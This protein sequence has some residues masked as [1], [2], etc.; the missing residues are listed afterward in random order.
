MW[1]WLLGGVIL[2]ACTLTFIVLAH[3]APMDTEIWPGGEPEPKPWET[4]E[5][6]PW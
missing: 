6:I 3:H 4:D 2:I 5:G 1:I